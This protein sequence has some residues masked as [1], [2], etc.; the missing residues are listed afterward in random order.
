MVKPIAVKA[1]KGAWYAGWRLVS[2][3]GSTLDVADEKG[4]DEAF[5]RPGASRGESAYPNIRFVSLA[6]VGTHVLFAVSGIA[7]S[8]K[9]L[10]SLAK[11]MLCLA[12]RNF[13]GF[14]MW[15]QA[16]ATAADLLWRVKQNTRL[17]REQRLP[18]DSY[19]SHIFPCDRDRRHK[20]N[21]VAVRV[22]DYRLDGAVDAEQV[23]RVV[24]TIRD[25]PKAPATELA[26]LYHQRLGDRTRL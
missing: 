18:D 2:L 12:D 7:L 3:D 16:T 11:G 6:E 19:L 15:T 22:I 26:A 13:F 1:T 10:P 9:V 17:E 5:G 23:Y 14:R 24:T 20:T 4:N 8:E 25:H 21:G